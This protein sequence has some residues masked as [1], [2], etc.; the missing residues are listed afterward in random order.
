MTNSQRLKDTYYS[1]LNEEM[2][3]KD[4]NDD[5]VSISTPFLD[6]NFDNIT[7]YAHFSGDDNIK[8]SDFGETIFN[9]EMAG[10]NLDRRSNAKKFLTLM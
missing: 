10:I 7:L 6:Q 8:L 2:I 4:E 5:Y 1:W 9:L 3:F